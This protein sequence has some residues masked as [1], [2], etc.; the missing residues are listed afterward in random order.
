MSHALAERVSDVPDQFEQRDV[1]TA[2]LL[3][4]AGYLDHP[5]ELTVAEVE[6]VLAHD[7][8]LADQ[9]WK[10]GHDQQMVGGWGLDRCGSCYRVQSFGTGRTMV[11][12]DR[13]QATAEF[14]VRYVGFMGDVLNRHH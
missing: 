11:V 3:K 6:D 10:R 2:T 7:P 1:S 9:W 5:A 4:E 12:P 14:I 8:H 13:L